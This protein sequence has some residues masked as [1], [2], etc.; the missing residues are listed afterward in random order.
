MGGL[1]KGGRG[2]WS[3]VG[4]LAVGSRLG[5]PHVLHRPGQRVQRHTAARDSG[6]GLQGG[7]GQNKMGVIK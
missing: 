7:C 6:A 2:L 3:Y 1:V 4:C 5:L